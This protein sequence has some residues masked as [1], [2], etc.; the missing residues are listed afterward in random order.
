MGKSFLATQ[1][2]AKNPSN[3]TRFLPDSI[4]DIISISWR[5]QV[6]GI[7]ALSSPRHFYMY[8]I[9]SLMHIIIRCCKHSPCQLNYQSS[10]RH[11]PA[12]GPTAFRSQ[13]L[14]STALELPC[15]PAEMQRLY[16]VF[17]L[18]R[19]CLTYCV[20]TNIS[21]QQ[22]ASS[23]A[24]AYPFIYRGREAMGPEIVP[25]GRSSSSSWNFHRFKPTNEPRQS[26]PPLDYR[27]FEQGL[28]V[29][30]Q[31]MPEGLLRP[32]RA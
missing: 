15:L 4:Y 28:L 30:L 3:Q 17:P 11:V 8:E 2:L 20:Q 16:Q 21:H 32:I 14:H 25:S 19:L 9:T 27:A 31:R 12:K 5:C 1:R 6:F 7:R 18:V 10:N 22:L 26:P 23:H 29:C 24:L 13:S